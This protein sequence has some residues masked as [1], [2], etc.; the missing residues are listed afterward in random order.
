MKLPIQAQPVSRKVSSTMLAKKA[1][2]AVGASWSCGEC[3]LSIAQCGWAIKDGPKPF[4]D[5]LAGLGAEGCADCPVEVNDW[6]VA[7]WG[8]GRPSHGGHPPGPPHH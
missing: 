6:V 4:R 5:C 8:G 1:T 3:A 2:N 7:H